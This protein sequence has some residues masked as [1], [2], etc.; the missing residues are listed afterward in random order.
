MLL[1]RRILALHAAGSTKGARSLLPRLAEMKKASPKHKKRYDEV[2]KEISVDPPSDVPAAES[3]RTDRAFQETPP[4][5]DS[6]KEPAG[7]TAAS[8]S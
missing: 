3:E 2:A 8:S 6:Q 1:A 5:S 7:T 4:E